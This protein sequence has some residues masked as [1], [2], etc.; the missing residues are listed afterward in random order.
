MQN[1]GL[2]IA[3]DVSIDRTKAIATNIERQAS[4]N[5]GITTKSG[6][7]FSH[8]APNFFDRILLDAPCSGEGTIGKTMDYFKRWNLSGIKKMHPGKFVR[9]TRR[10]GQR[11]DRHRGSIGGDEGTGRQQSVHFF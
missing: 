10:R 8:L 9:P 5:V 4:A 7:I 11:G 3:N 6:E 1:S 2:I